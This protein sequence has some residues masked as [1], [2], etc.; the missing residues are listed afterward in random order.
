MLIAMESSQDG[1]TTTSHL[2]LAGGRSSINHPESS[3]WP[4]PDVELQNSDF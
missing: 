2:G 4:E 1:R 3:I